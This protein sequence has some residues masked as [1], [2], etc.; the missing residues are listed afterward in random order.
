[1]PEAL[2]FIKTACGFILF[3]NI[4]LKRSYNKLLF[5]FFEFSL[6]SQLLLGLLSLIVGF[7][8]VFITLLILSIIQLI[9]IGITPSR[10]K[11]STTIQISGFFKTIFHL[12]LR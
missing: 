8:D 5:S 3:N 6:L 7:N 1:M 11:F 2:P 4:E 12:S 9:S 10:F